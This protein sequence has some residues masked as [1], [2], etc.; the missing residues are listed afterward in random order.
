M[1]SYGFL[2]SHEADARRHDP[3]KD[4]PTVVVLAVGEGD[5][6]TVLVAPI[7]SRDPA[8]PEAIALRPSAVAGLD[9]GGWIIPW[10]V[11]AFRWPGPDVRPAIHPSGAWWRIG[12]LNPPL[13]R[14]LREAIQAAL[15]DRRTR[16]TQ[17]RE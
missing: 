15:N 14:R 8:R 10:E 17:R 4:R 12:A 6:P 13:R 11:N 3:I 7:T 16:I 2:W 9:R 5:N 1:I